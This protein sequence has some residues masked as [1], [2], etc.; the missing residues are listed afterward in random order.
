MNINEL[1]DK[2]KIDD[3]FRCAHCGKLLA[4]DNI[5]HGKYEIKCIRCG[6][7]N[8]LFRDNKEQIIIT[9][10]NGIILFAN[11]LTEMVT[12]YKLEEIIGKTPAIWGGLMP[13]EFYKAIWK[14]ISEEKKTV[15]TVL[16]NRRKN[17]EKYLANLRISPVLDVDGSVK[18]FV[19]IESIHKK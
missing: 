15:S 13:K 9:D 10:P 14:Q 18:F 11:N 5:E 7:L 1:E 16:T 8:V 2:E 19:G 12:G 3:E 4:K 6:V 17:G